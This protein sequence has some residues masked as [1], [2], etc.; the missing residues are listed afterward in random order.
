MTFDSLI[1]LINTMDAYFPERRDNA[2]IWA[3]LDEVIRGSEKYKAEL[4]QNRVSLF[5]LVVIYSKQA[6]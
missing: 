4:E 5:K 3:K 6:R 1:T 2:L